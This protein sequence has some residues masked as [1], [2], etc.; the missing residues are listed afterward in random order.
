MAVFNRESRLNKTSYIDGLI[1]ETEMSLPSLSALGKR[2]VSTGWD[3][4]RDLP[5]ELILKVLSRLR[6][7]QHACLLARQMCY[8]HILDCNNNRMWRNLAV[9]VFRF[10]DDFDNP[11]QRVEKPEDGD[12]DYDDWV[13]YLEVVD[14]VDEGAVGWPNASSW[15][16]HFHSLCILYNKV[17]DELKKPTQVG[18]NSLDRIMS[19]HVSIPNYVATSDRFLAFR[20]LRL[21]SNL[22]HTMH[23]LELLRARWLLEVTQNTM[24]TTPD[25]R[26]RHTMYKMAGLDESFPKEGF[27]YNE[28]Y[29]DFVILRNEYLEEFGDEDKDVFPILGSQFVLRSLLHGVDFINLRVRRNPQWGGEMRVIVEELIG[30]QNYSESLT[31]CTVS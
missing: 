15:R 26:S 18:G 4:I 16:L 5:Q 13:E 27:D 7:P 19:E 25:G 24:Q 30:P 10:S 29:A 22:K 21:L 17:Y 1:E 23:Q 28:Q 2:V 12:D 3:P 8:E 6:S 20:A 11:N 14:Q 9:A 31:A